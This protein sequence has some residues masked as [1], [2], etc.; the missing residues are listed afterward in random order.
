MHVLVERVYETT[1]VVEYKIKNAILIRL[2]ISIMKEKISNHK[3][4]R[5][6]K[7]YETTIVV[8]VIVENKTINEQ[9]EFL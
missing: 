4:N 6:V 1:I 2:Q 9:K 8:N 3:I 7:Q 5:I